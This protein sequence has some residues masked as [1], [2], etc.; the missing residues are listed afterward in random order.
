MI[1]VT[2]AV[3]GGGSN[4]FRVREWFSLRAAWF[5]GFLAIAWCPGCVCWSIVGR[6]TRAHPFLSL[7]LPLFAAWLQPRAVH[8]TSDMWQVWSRPLGAKGSRMQ[9]RRSIGMC[10][11]NR[12]LCDAI[13]VRVVSVGLLLLSTLAARGTVAFSFGWKLDNF[14][15]STD[16]PGGLASLAAGLRA[17]VP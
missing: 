6:D 8:A 9:Q 2:A 17:F 5:L 3:L 15:W 16:F 4:C 14:D 1:C 10:Q 13:R 11:L 12:R 7:T